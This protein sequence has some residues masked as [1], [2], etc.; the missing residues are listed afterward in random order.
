MVCRPVDV[1]CTRRAAAAEVVVRV[2]ERQSQRFAH[3][4][5]FRVHKIHPESCVP[6]ECARCLAAIAPALHGRSTN[7]QSSLVKEP[8]VNVHLTFTD[9]PHPKHWDTSRVPMGVHSFLSHSIS[10]T[11]GQTTNQL[12]VE[13][14]LATPERSLRVYLPVCPA[15]TPACPARSPVH[16]NVLLL[17]T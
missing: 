3:A 7:M 13:L 15:C 4:A 5:H 9:H 12:G 8:I 14:L 11:V 17:R 16:T 6:V 10:N 1:P 2:S